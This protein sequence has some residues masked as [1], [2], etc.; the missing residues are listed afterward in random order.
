MD[1]PTLIREIQA[2]SPEDRA[3]VIGAVSDDADAG[4]LSHLSPEQLADLDRRVAEDDANPDAGS[5]G[6]S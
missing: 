3:R 2:L 4:L 6:R 5:P 1:V